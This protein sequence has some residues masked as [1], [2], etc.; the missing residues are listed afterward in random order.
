MKED[1][2]TGE[3]EAKASKDA[4]L[5]HCLCT[6]KQRATVRKRARG[7]SFGKEIRQS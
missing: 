7:V 2:K 5:V 4:G 1:E 6:D 3:I